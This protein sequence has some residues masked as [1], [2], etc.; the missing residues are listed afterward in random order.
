MKKRQKKNLVIAL[1]LISVFTILGVLGNTIKV[2]Y[3]AITGEVVKEPYVDTEC[4]FKDAIYKIEW[5]GN[6][7]SCIQEE[8]A[9]Y[10]SY[11]AEKNFWGNCIRYEQRCASNKCVKYGADCKIKIINQEKEPMTFN[12]DL[13]KF[14]RDTRISQPI[15]TETFGVSALG[16]RIVS[17]SYTRLSTESASCQYQLTNNPQIQVCNQQTKYKDVEKEKI[18]T[19]YETVWESIAGKNNLEKI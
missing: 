10:S 6:E 14:N 2:P 8:C 13:S 9:T 16:D 3:S 11:C 7:A 12:L 4:Y 18:I 1:S 15:K 17:W 19:K 5:A